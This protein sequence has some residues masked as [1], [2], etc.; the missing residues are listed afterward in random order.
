LYCKVKHKEH[1]HKGVHPGQSESFYTFPVGRV[2]ER[3]AL[4][5]ELE[6]LREQWREAEEIASIADDL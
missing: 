4:A 2:I 1:G 5:G 6:L 3:R